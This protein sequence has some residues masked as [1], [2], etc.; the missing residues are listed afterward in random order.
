ME[1]GQKLGVSGADCSGYAAAHPEGGEMFLLFVHA[2][3]GGRM[4]PSATHDALRAAGCQQAYLFTHEQN[5]RAGQPMFWP[6]TVSVT[7]MLPRVALEYGH[8]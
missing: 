6:F 2:A 4:L 7:S 8:T 1:T 3:Y 5:E